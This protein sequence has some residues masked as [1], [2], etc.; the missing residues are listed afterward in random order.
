MTTETILSILIIVT[1]IL[2]IGI[3]VFWDVLLDWWNGDEE[4]D[5]VYCRG[6]GGSDCDDCEHTMALQEMPGPPTGYIH[7]PNEDTQPYE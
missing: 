4:F 6:C 1:M 3:F 5:G 2:G 7:D